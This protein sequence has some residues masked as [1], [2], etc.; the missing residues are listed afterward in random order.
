M[1]LRAGYYGLKNSVKKALENLAADIADAKI[2]KSVGDGLSLSAQGALSANI[3]S[4]TME[5]KDHKLAAKVSTPGVEVKTMTYT[6]DGQTTSSIDFSNEDALPT[7]ILG[8][9]GES[10]NNYYAAAVP[11]LYGVQLRLYCYW[12][13]SSGSGKSGSQNIVSYTDNNTVMHIAGANSG[14]ALNDNGKEY[15]VYY[16]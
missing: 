15:T 6:G 8:I 1:A 2:I 9:C 7:V 16:I 4:D 5:F 12:A 11:C 10:D 13:Q 3:D 14:E